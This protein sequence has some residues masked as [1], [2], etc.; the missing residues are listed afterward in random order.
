MALSVSA[1]FNMIDR[2]RSAPNGDSEVS[3]SAVVQ[4]AGVVGT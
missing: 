1:V 2:R 3:M 4:E